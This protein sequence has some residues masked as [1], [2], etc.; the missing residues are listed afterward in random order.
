MTGSPLALP[1]AVLDGL[2]MT[3]IDASDPL[4]VRGTAGL[5]AAIPAT[6]GF[7]PRDSLVQVCLAG[8][9]AQVGPMGRVD[10][11]PPRGTTPREYTDGVTSTLLTVARRHA[12]SVVLVWYRSLA[13]RRP[14][15]VDAMVGALDGAG[16]PVRDVISVCA[17]RYRHEGVSINTPRVSPGPSYPLLGAGDPDVLRLRASA[18]LRGRTILG[19][20]DDLRRSIDGPAAGAALDRAW[21]EFD[22]CAGRVP[23]QL[24]DYAAELDLALVECASHHSL[25]AGRAATIVLGLDDPALCSHLVGRSVSAH[26]EPWT[27]MLAACARQTPTELAGDLCALLALVAYCDGDG[28]LAQVAVD[29]SLLSRSGHSMARL[30]MQVMAAGVHP[31]AVAARFRGAARPSDCGR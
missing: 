4:V 31:D 1:L 20:R 17:G 6:L 10:L 2:L 7:P 12:D 26:D 16:V 28:A 8:P 30:L 22:R 14:A 18:A 19:D 23:Q 27:A 25:T 9:R 21:A 3:K 11:D 29:R 13:D 15:L 5:L 24:D